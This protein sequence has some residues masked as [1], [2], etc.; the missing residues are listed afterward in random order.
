MM[1]GHLEIRAEIDD[2]KGLDIF[3]ELQTR[4]VQEGP[5][6]LIITGPTGEFR[7]KTTFTPTSEVGVLHSVIGGQEIRHTRTDIKPEDWPAFADELNRRNARIMDKQTNEACADDA[8][9]RKGAITGTINPSYNIVPYEDLI[10][11]A[12]EEKAERLKKSEQHRQTYTETGDP[13]I[14][15]NL[16]RSFRHALEENHWIVQVVA[17]WRRDGEHDLLNKAFGLSPGQKRGANETLNVYGLTVVEVDSLK[18]RGSSDTRAFQAV[19]ALRG[20]GGFDTVKK[21]YYKMRKE[22][23]QTYIEEDEDFYFLTFENSRVSLHEVDIFGDYT[24]VI[25]KDPTKRSEIKIRV[26]GRAIADD[27]LSRLQAMF[28]EIDH[29]KPR[30]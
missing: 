10:K 15:I 13:N 28:S 22:M 24:L 4:H 19:S 23:Y 2:S 9:G 8:S 17:R 12:L 3:K 7:F 16:I 5:D 14:V 21:S 1:G 27:D 20:F 29:N 25:P 6:L 11:K 26:E 30:P 18:S